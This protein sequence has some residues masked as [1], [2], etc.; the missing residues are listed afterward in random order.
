MRIKLE[1]ECIH[2]F[3]ISLYFFCSWK[4]VYTLF[5]KGC[6]Q[7]FFFL[8]NVCIGTQHYLALY[9]D[10]TY[11]CVILLLNFNI[12]IH[13]IYFSWI[14]KYFPKYY[15]T[16]QIFLQDYYILFLTFPLGGS[17][18]SLTVSENKYRTVS[19]VYEDYS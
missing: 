7:R 15:I 8:S 19:L 2:I 13:H 1:D 9:I 4:I 10:L 3:I 17:T 5:P 11:I 16:S 6:R 12:T 14:F 18:R